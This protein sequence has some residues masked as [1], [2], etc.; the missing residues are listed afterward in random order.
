VV[1]RKIVFFWGGG[2]GG[3]FKSHFVNVSISE[4]I[5][6]IIINIMRL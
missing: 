1:V 5:L 3:G 4:P 2:R 6:F